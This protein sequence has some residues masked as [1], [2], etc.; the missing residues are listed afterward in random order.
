MTS[1]NSLTSPDAAT[2]TITTERMK[3]KWNDEYWLML[4]EVFL[5]KPIGLKPMYSHDMINL[6]LE[7][8]FPPQYLYKK[9]FRLR[10]L[11]T[12]LIERLWGKYS[13]N[14]KLLAKE[15]NLLRQMNGFNN[16][17]AFYEG[18]DVT[19]TFE[20]DFKPLPEHNDITPVM[21]IMALD[22]YFRLT[23]NTMVPE[24]PEIV[25]LA[26]RMGITPHRITE[27]MDA[28]MFCDPYLT[29][30]GHADNALLAPCKEIWNKY[31]NGDPSQ[32]AS[33]AAQLNE[34]FN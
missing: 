23:P 30:K 11:D 33:L 29:N 17:E 28:Y 4:M 9:M 2:K 20:A 18:V 12:P 10:Q 27:I 31:G 6:A 15:V 26:K 24:T 21:L 8:H 13:R 19:E 34:Y 22:L 32:L 3:T 5:K 14:P 1:H 7:L 25:A 16:A